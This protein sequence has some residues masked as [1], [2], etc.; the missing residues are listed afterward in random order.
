MLA[1]IEL[2]EGAI[3]SSYPISCFSIQCAVRAENAAS[4]WAV[5]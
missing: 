4:A 2:L 5:M 3:C 1:C